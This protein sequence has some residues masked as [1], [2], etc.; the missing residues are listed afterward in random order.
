MLSAKTEVK[1]VGWSQ[2]TRSS[3]LVFLLNEAVRIKLKNLTAPDMLFL[4]TSNDLLPVSGL[5][6]LQTLSQLLFHLPAFLIFLSRPLMTGRNVEA[7]P[8][9][10]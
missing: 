1:V 10:H 8:L 4:D 9:A 5:L 7:R 3:M 2:A 6:V